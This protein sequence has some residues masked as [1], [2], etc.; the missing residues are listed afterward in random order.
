MTNTPAF[1]SVVDPF[2][3]EIG[4]RRSIVSQQDTALRGR[5]FQHRRIFMAEQTD[6]L[7]ADEIQVRT[8]TE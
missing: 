7:D 5:P 2:V 3:S 4:D 6:I 1:V 8:P